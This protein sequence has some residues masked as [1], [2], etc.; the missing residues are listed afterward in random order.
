MLGSALDGGSSQLSHFPSCL[1][2]LPSLY[3]Q[4]WD[5]RT[6]GLSKQAQDLYLVS[7]LGI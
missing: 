1:D 2:C 5:K 4:V 7:L 3:H 6:M